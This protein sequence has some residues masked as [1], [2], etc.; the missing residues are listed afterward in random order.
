MSPGGTA[1]K[2]HAVATH[3]NVKVFIKL[4]ATG[5]TGVETCS[6]A[7]ASSDGFSGTV[8]SIAAAAADGSFTGQA[9]TLPSTFT[10]V[11]VTATS[12]AA[13][14]TA[15]CLVDSMVISGDL[16]VAA[17]ALTLP[18]TSANGLTRLHKNC[19][20]L[21]EAGVARSYGG[22][23]WEP[24][25]PAPL[26]VTCVSGTCTV[27]VPADTVYCLKEV[28]T[29]LVPGSNNAAAARL[30]SQATFGATVASIAE[31]VTT[32]AN[33]VANFLTA[34]FAATPTSLR[35]HVRERSNPKPK[36]DGAC[37]CFLRPRSPL[38]PLPLRLAIFSRDVSF[39]SCHL[40][41]RRG[42]FVSLLFV[43]QLLLAG[44]FYLDWNTDLNMGLP[45]AGT[46]GRVRSACEAGSR[47]NAHSF[48]RSDVGRDFTA[49]LDD[50]TVGFYALR[51][52]STLLTEVPAASWTRGEGTF[53][54]CRVYEFRGTV[55]NQVRVS[56]GHSSFTLDLPRA[57][58]CS[59][60][61]PQ[62]PR[63]RF[64]VCCLHGLPRFVAFYNCAV[65]IH[66]CVVCADG[67]ALHAD[68]ARVDQL[69]IAAGLHPQPTGPL[70]LAQPGSL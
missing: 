33:S 22:R 4:A 25:Q 32:H 67:L 34:Q 41:W 28:D 53:E 15:E 9:L 65:Q 16:I 58:L 24:V 54:V 63:V 50:V 30:L 44:H 52:G 17:G 7:V 46:Y 3:A 55:G 35:E 60:Q 23:D 5:L 57:A 21:I 64:F 8:L 10:T 20:S 48:Q 26:P 19:G 68:L 11:T 70:R 29:S 27:T 69:W 43:S 47:W 59:S 39:L 62:S 18:T 45:C 38:S 12:T 42:I 1:T 40:L 6:V 51:F 31:V 2:A 37:L 56:R 36:P 61:W 14:G 49:T 66:D 13:A